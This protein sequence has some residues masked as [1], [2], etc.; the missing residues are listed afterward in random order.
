VTASPGTRLAHQPALDGLRGAA[1]AAV[2]LFHAGLD[3]F[4]GGYLGVSV[5]FTLSGFLITSLLLVEHGGTG[6]LAIGPFLARRARR[7]LP[8]ST[9]CLLGV[10]VAAR[11]GWFGEV[12]D[13][14]RDVLGSLAQIQNWVLLA[15]GDSYTDLLARAGG[16][17]SPL[18]HYWSLAIEE[19]F[20]WVWPAAMTVLLARRARLQVRLGAVTLAAAVAAPLI[21]WRWGPD[22][23]Y[24][25][26]PARAAEILI[27]AW[28]AVWLAD[29]RTPLVSGWGRVAPAAGAA[30][31]VGVVTFPS[32][33][34]PAYSG[35]LPLVAVVTAL[36]LLGLQ[37]DGPATRALSCRP[38]VGLG[39]ISYGVY[40]FHW[41]VFVALAP[42]RID[43]DGWRLLVL[44]LAVTLALALV[45]YHLIESPI[46]AWRGRP[47]PTLAL[48]GAALGAV[49]LVAV[50]AV[51]RPATPYWQL[52]TSPGTFPPTA[53]PS[54]PTG[55]G[56]TDAPVDDPGPGADAEDDTGADTDSSA[57][58]DGP[59]DGPGVGA[60]PGA[61]PARPMEVL[62]LGD[63]T[64]QSLGNGLVA[65]SAADPTRSSTVLATSP[66]CGFVRTGTVLTDG[67]VDF[68]GPCAE[69]LDRQLPALL[70]ASPPDVAVLLV[71]VRD[72]EPRRWDDGALL[73][74][75]DPVYVDH[76]RED[77]LALT[78]QLRAAGTTV[79]WLR[80][81]TADPY[82]V[83]RPGLL[84]PGPERDALESLLADLAAAPDDGVHLL[85]L[86]GWVDGDPVARAE[87][88]RPD[89]LHW[90][91]EAAL[92]VTE[93]WLGPELLRLVALDD[94]RPSPGGST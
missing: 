72:I 35:A 51:P 56:P 49:A 59:A 18:E 45:S 75:A 31:L 8:A 42:E 92:D 32:S 74:G 58:P 3:P 89:G 25:A 77:Y 50:L 13:L 1:V 70:A 67:D 86:Q 69:I 44:R 10:V 54:A 48:G 76:R 60:E 15:S 91:P 11:L 36:L 9:L 65:W 64:A 62:V 30:L 66:G 90:T 28:L 84:G 94:R 12:P 4:R 27:G 29:R 81:P 7:L 52:S 23:A 61:A 68:V 47:A 80:P 6:R 5:F 24:W 83:G 38:A 55:T 39:R 40:L 41:P 63:S 87:A 19:Q 73:D 57:A 34:G 46:R 71:T 43:L 88:A 85:D 22:A 33:S 37:V 17:T 82:W 21:A 26:T 93:R 14:R 16:L 2:L 20:Y 78:E 53:E 79:V